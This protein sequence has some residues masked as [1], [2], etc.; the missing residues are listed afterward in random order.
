MR[1]ARHDVPSAERMILAEDTSQLIQDTL[2]QY[3]ATLNK[4]YTKDVQSIFDQVNDRAITYGSSCV[5]IE[6]VK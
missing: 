5:K 1:L 4:H 2:R 3:R 6:R